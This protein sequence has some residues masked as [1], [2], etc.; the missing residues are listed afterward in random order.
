MKVYATA[1]EALP[2]PCGT[3]MKPH[4]VVERGARKLKLLRVRCPACKLTS[5]SARIDRVWVAWNW[6][7]E[8]RRRAGEMR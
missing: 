6:T 7:V 5:N 1:A 2:C 8:A 4:P 3:T